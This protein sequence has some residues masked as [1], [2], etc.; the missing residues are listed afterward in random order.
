MGADEFQG[1]TWRGFHHHM[2][3][4]MLTQ[5]FV[6]THRLETGEANGGFDSFEKV[7]RQLVRTASIQRLIDEHGLDR[8]TAETIGTDMLRGSSEWS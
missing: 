4:V 2:A 5:V 6:A 7:A 3:V 8:A 1:R